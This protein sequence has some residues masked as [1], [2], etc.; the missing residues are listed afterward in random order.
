MRRS[1]ILTLLAAH[2]AVT[3]RAHGRRSKNPSEH[4]MTMSSIL[5]RQLLME[6]AMKKSAAKT[7]LARFM[8]RA[9]VIAVVVTAL[10]MTGVPLLSAQEMRGIFNDAD[11]SWHQS[12]IDDGWRVRIAQGSVFLISGKNLATASQ[13][14][15][16]SP[17][18]LEL[19]GTSV[20]V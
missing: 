9:V 19:G 2:I 7:V 8:M 13:V 11:R 6:L 15:G 14:A 4:S 3:R 5:R 16:S 20:Q 10:I 17:L 12:E 1:K 18:P